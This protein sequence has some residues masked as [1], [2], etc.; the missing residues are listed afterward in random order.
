MKKVA[1]RSKDR[2]AMKAAQR[3]VKQC[4]K[5]AKDS[6]RRKVE[7]KLSESRMREFWDGVNTIAGHRAKSV[8]ASGTVDEANRLNNFFNRLDQSRLTKPPLPL[9][10]QPPLPLLP[11]N[12]IAPSSPLSTSPRPPLCITINQ[13]RGELR[14]L[15][16]RKGVGPDKVPS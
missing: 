9:S 7:Q 15:H 4:L 3:E 6:Y 2:E 8:T 1:F 13:V 14:K 12:N 16:P 5:K 11:D 10:L